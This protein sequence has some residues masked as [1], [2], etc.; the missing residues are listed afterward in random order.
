MEER[1]HEVAYQRSH[2]GKEHDDKKS[3]ADWFW[4]LGHLTT[5]A[6]MP[7]TTREKLRHRIIAAAAVLANWY[8]HRP[9]TQ[10]MT[11]PNSYDEKFRMMVEQ[12]GHDDV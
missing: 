4:L 5:K 6:M 2:W 1:V 10:P 12:K 9:M 11:R 7:G 3:D 8:S